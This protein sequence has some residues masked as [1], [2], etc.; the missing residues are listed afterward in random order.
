MSKSNNRWKHLV[1]GLLIGLGAND[2]Y[3]AAYVGTGVSA[4]LELKKRH[5]GLGE[6]RPDGRWRCGR[7]IN[8]DIAMTGVNETQIVAKGISELRH[9]DN[10]LYH[11]PAAVGRPDGGLLPLVQDGHR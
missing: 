2:V 7:T 6:L 8:Q 5:V 10:H 11:V 4:A 9:N 1:D 3:C